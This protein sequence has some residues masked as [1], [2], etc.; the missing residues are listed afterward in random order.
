M[1]KKI[2][3]LSIDPYRCIGCG[4]CVQSCFNDVLRM[5]RGKAAVAYP[6]D[7]SQCFACEVD[8]PREAV[9]IGLS[10]EDYRKPPLVMP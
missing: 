8:C 4:V 1:A 6:E 10:E 9:I 5:K 3:I 2:R 7:C